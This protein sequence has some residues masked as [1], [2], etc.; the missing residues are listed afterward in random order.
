M[1]TGTPGPLRRLWRPQG[2]VLA[3]VALA[4]DLVAEPSNTLTPQGF[5]DRLA[6][7]AEAGVRSRC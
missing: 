6:P 3:G 1:L 2:A 5:V 7:L 4:R